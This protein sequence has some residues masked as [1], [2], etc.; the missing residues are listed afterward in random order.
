MLIEAFAAFKGHFDFL[1]LPIDFS[2]RCN[3]G[4]A[5]INFTDFATIP[6]FYADFQGIIFCFYDKFV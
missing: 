4:Y 3:V 5:F 6:Q 2:N 1:Y